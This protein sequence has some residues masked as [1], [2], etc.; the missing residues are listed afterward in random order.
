MRPLYESVKEDKSKA[1][2]M[3]EELGYYINDQLKQKWN[4]EDAL[5]YTTKIEE[6]EIQKDYIH[7]WK[8]EKT[9]TKNGD[10][11]SIRITMQE[12]EAINQKCKELG[13]L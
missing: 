9:I 5:T 4:E 7:F 2:K 12:L 11:E 10:V 8:D 3:F 1:D 13:W 6:E